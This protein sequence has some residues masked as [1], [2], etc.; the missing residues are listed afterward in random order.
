M[1]SKLEREVRF[2][3]VYAFIATLI[4][5]VLFLCA[6]TQQAQKPKFEEIDV[7]RINVVE[8]DG[9]IRFIITNRERSPRPIEHGV[10]YGPSGGRRTGI[11]FYNDEGTENG[12]LTLGSYRKGD[13]YEAVGLLGFDQYDQD[14]SVVLQYYEHD[15]RRRAGL[16][17]AEYPTTITNRQRSEQY[18][19]ANKL[20]DGP[21]KQQ[22]LDKLAELDAK[23][24]GYFGKDESGAAV[25]RLADGNGKTRLRL[26]VDAAG[27]ARI[28]FLDDS[29]KV[30]QA[31]PDA[32]KNM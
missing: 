26:R 27:L 28:E 22:T 8:K 7:E 12:G 14:Q 3:K 24:R 20:P 19:Q 1:E 17:I 13:R 32:G 15:G 11:I 30:V 29:G 18:E 23:T 10:P 25:L 4:S 16:A 5:S 31:L 2:L 6:F 21:A 9:K